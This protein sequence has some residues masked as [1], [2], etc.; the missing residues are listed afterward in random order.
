MKCEF[1]KCGAEATHTWIPRGA[2]RLFVCY[3]CSQQKS[4]ARYLSELVPLDHPEA[5]KNIALRTAEEFHMEY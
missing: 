2:S 3:P 5:R 1:G 4:F